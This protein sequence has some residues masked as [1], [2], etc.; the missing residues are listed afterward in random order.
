MDSDAR[1]VFR[2]R[3]SNAVDTITFDLFRH[4]A[5]RTISCAILGPN[6]FL[7]E[8]GHGEKTGERLLRG[9]FVRGYRHRSERD[10][11]PEQGS[12]SLKSRSGPDELILCTSADPINLPLYI[13]SQ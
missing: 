2:V 12:Q 8:A 4:D 1:W 11:R 5:H 9:P 10:E 6:F 3:I 13:D 7:I